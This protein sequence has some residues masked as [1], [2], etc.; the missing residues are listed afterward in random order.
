MLGR[1]GEGE[2]M[3]GSFEISKT[4]RNILF[5]KTFPYRNGKCPN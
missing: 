2:G 1:L 5:Q 3:S 4:C